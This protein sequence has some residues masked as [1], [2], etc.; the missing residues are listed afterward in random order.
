MHGLLVFLFYMTTRYMA[1]G[2][3]NTPYY[4]EWT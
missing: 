1:V 2:N 3:L 4:K